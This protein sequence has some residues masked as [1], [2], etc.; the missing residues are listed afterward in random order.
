MNFWNP[1]TAMLLGLVLLGAALLVLHLA[2]VLRT[3]RATGLPRALR[4]LSWLP[5]VT[6][7]AGFWCGAKLLSLLWCIV[8]AAYIVLRTLA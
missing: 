4:W 2:L 3:L 8:A 5:P 7:V 6:P 1:H